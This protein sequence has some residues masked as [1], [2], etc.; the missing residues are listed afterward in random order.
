M[1]EEESFELIYAVLEMEYLIDEGYDYAEIYNLEEDGNIF[2]DAK[3]KVCKMAV[4]AM[5]KYLNKDSTRE[6]VV[7][8]LTGVCHMLPSLVQSVCNDIMSSGAHKLVDWI[9]EHGTTDGAC[10]GIKACK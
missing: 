2:K 8:V 5:Q 3:C 7:K 10:K 1:T 6:A 4:G 9:I